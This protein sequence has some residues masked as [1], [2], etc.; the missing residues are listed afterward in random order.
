MNQYEN[1]RHVPNPITVEQIAAV[2]NL[3]VAYFY[4]VDDD[5]AQLLVLFYRSDEIRRQRILAVAGAA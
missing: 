2:L 4:S 1:D 5:E 3:P